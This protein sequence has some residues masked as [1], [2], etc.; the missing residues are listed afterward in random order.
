MDF[1]PK[2]PGNERCEFRNCQKNPF[3]SPPPPFLV[4]LDQ[5]MEWLMYSNKRITKYY[6]FV[7]TIHVSNNLTYPQTDP[8]HLRDE[9]ANGPAF[10]CLYHMEFHYLN[11][12]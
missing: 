11:E 1:I 10:L 3:R 12:L 5:S 2:S 4:K 8:F 7:K 9:V 6:R